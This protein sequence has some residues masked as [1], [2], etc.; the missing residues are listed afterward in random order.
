MTNALCLN[1]FG[2]HLV[3]ECRSQKVCQV[4][5]A[6][7]H[8]MIHGGSGATGLPGTSAAG[9]TGSD[10]EL[11]PIEPAAVS[12]NA[13]VASH[14]ARSRSLASSGKKLLVTAMVTVFTAGGTPVPVRAL[15]DQC[16]EASFVTEALAQRL[17]LPRTSASVTV[18]GIGGIS[19]MVTRGRVALKLGSRV[20]SRFEFSVGAL[21][22]PKL[23]A[24]AP[25]PRVPVAC[26]AHLDGL[27]FAN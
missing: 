2:R 6:K 15:L 12:S 16:S 8:N 7:Y 3:R 10:V 18:T 23:C 20:D 13:V 4:C 19:A 24:Y 1:C 27:T 25:P 21:V 22:L 11:P 5:T 14:S 9:T 26:W 17:S